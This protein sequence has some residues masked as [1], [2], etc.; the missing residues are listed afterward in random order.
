MMDVDIDVEDPGVIL[1]QLQDGD[2]NVVHVA[3]STRLKLLQAKN[4]NINFGII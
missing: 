2:N 1:Q 3:E 4:Y